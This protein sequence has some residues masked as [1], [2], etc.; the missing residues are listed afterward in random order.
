MPSIRLTTGAGSTERTQQ[1]GHRIPVV[2]SQPFRT[3][4]R[5]ATDGGKR[6]VIWAADGHTPSASPS[7]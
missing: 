5:K 6:K 4:S 2:A 1:D 7:Q 3:A